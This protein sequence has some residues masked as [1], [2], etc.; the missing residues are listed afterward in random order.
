MKKKNRCKKFQLNEMV[1]WIDELTAIMFHVKITQEE[2][3]KQTL[4]KKGY[5]KSY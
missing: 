1:F 5:E 4:G 2:F 3:L